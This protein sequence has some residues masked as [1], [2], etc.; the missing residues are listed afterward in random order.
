MLSESTAKTRPADSWTVHPLGYEEDP[1]TKARALDDGAASVGADHV[2]Q[3]APLAKPAAFNTPPP[4][5]GVPRRSPVA[6]AGPSSEMLA[7]PECD[8]DGSPM[9]S[10]PE[11][12]PDASGIE[13]SIPVGADAFAPV[14][15]EDDPPQN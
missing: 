8:P 5:K 10:I 15:V 3:S 11:A 12:S 4:P 6:C 1:E 7:Q 14:E 2:V 13:D 9:A